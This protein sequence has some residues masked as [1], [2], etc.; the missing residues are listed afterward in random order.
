MWARWHVLVLVFVV[1]VILFKN[2]QH[3]ARLEEHDTGDEEEK[4]I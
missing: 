1:K 3:Y 4:K 2:R